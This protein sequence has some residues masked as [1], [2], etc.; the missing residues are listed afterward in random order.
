MTIANGQTL[1]AEGEDLARELETSWLF[2]EAY[3]QKR[4]GR[5]QLLGKKTINGKEGIA[6]EMVM[7]KSGSTTYYLDPATYLPFAQD[8]GEAGL[9][10]VSDW[11]AVSGVMLPHAIS[12]EPQPG[13]SINLGDI[14]YEA[15]VKVTPAMFEKK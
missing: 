14:K 3:L 5:V 7:P 9:I 4:G 2:P 12:L 11:R 15:N 6:V 13:V 1:A 8:Q 10:T